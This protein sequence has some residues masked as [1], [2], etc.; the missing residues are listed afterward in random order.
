MPEL[1]Q[2]SLTPT[3]GAIVDGVDLRDADE[4]VWSKI[5]HAFTQYKVVFI[6]NQKL[7]LDDL[8]RI[9][10]NIGDLMRLPYIEPVSTHPEVIAVLKE[11]DEINMGVFGGDWHSDFSFL[12]A[13]PMASI[14]YAQE[15]PP[16]GGDTLWADMAAAYR[17]LPEHLRSQVDGRHVVHTGAPYGVDN[18]PELDEQ[19]RGSM[20]VAR[21]NPE[22]DAE[23]RHP[24]VCR[25]P[26]SGELMLF[27]NPTY[28]TRFADASAQDS[29][30]LLKAIFDHCT[31]PEF[32]C[33]FRWS[34]GCIALWDNRATMHYAVN[35]YD[36][37]RRLMYRTTIA[38]HAPMGANPTSC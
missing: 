34:E 22:A 35:D 1:N 33:R 37:H 18:A 16:V 21:K 11:A 7:D 2:P 8:V 23:V 5:Q 6:L 31:R 4:R 25:H 12:P 9:S 38:G 24:A 19:F 32:T 29:A 10:R 20:T 13:P 30:E 17:T 26:A 14:L 3:L 36:G 27:V 15:L 28:T